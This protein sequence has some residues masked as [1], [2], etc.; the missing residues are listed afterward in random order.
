MAAEYFGLSDGGLV[1]NLQHASSTD[2]PSFCI[3]LTGLGAFKPFFHF[4]TRSM[5]LRIQFD[6]HSLA[7][8]MT[9]RPHWAFEPDYTSYMN[10]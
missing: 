6:V 1:M 9:L 4:L 3:R 8:A 2:T 7:P 10:V 5:T